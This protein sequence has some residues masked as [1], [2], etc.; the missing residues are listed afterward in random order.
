MARKSADSARISKRSR[1]QRASSSAAIDA[2]PP[3]YSEPSARHAP[4]GPMEPATSTPSPVP[5]HAA[6]AMATE[7]DMRSAA[8][9]R[10]TL[11]CC[12]SSPTSA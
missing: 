3:E 9:A 12:A 10:L 2:Y 4:Y 1:C 7:D 5:T 6:R 8:A 11:R